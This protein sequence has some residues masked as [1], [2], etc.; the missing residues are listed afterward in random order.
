VK[1]A[2][3]NPYSV[4]TYN[5][6]YHNPYPT[7]R[8]DA[9]GSRTNP[10]TRTVVPPNGP[11]NHG[12]PGLLPEQHGR[13]TAG[14]KPTLNNDD[15]NRPSRVRRT[16]NPASTRRSPHFGE[17][18]QSTTGQ[19]YKEI[20]PSLCQ[21]SVTQTNKHRKPSPNPVLRSSMQSKRREVIDVD[22]YEDLGVTVQ[23]TG[24]V[25]L[26]RSLSPDEL[27][28]R[29]SNPPHK[30]SPTVQDILD[31]PQPPS[32]H[33]FNQKVKHEMPSMPQ[34]GPH[35]RALKAHLDCLPPVSF[36][37]PTNGAEISSDS[38]QDADG[39]DELPPQRSPGPSRSK[40]KFTPS[41]TTEF[42][43]NHVRDIVQLYDNQHGRSD[44]PPEVDLVAK[45]AQKAVRVSRVGAMKR[46]STLTRVCHCLSPC[47][48]LG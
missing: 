48:Q 13:F 38:I 47:S 6:L 16:Y 31:V 39:F 10:S 18:G 45:S 14:K 1:S 8:R 26:D 15:T 40:R 17:A 33:P 4:Q 27:Q 28:L 44:W 41:G 43:D 24:S 29:P 22:R 36:R 5:N 21:K 3:S 46:K 9:S 7:N 32:E 37:Q 12:P 11:P 30:S 35:T 25:S 19:T 23:L 34:S 20:N 42:T 2:T